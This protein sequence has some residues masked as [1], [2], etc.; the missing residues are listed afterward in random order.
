[1]DKME[2]IKKGN[3]MTTEDY[4]KFAN[5]VI[6]EGNCISTDK[7]FV[8]LFKDCRNG[9]LLRAF[10]LSEL[11]NRFKK[12]NYKE[13]ECTNKELKEFFYVSINRIEKAKADLIK[14]GFISVVLR[15]LPAKTHITVNIEKIYKEVSKLNKKQLTE[16]KNKF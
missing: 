1:M 15:G 2:P 12:N 8:T 16:E 11:I 4:I 3:N 9:N 14:K 13:F 6:A 7:E 10:M 5:E